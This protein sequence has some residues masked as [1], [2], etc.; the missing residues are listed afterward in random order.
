MRNFFLLSALLFLTKEGEAKLLNPLNLATLEKHSAGNSVHYLPEPGP[1]QLKPHNPDNAKPTDE[2]IADGGYPSET[3]TV[4]TEDGYILRIHRIPYARGQEYNLSRPVVFLQ[5]GLL[6]S[7]ADWVVTGPGHGL[8]F[9][10]ADAGYDVWMGNYRGNTYS[11]NH[12][13]PKLSKK[14]YWTFSWDEMARFDLPA[15]LK[16]MMAVTGS[17]RFF[18]I[19]HSMGTLTYYTA[20]NYHDWIAPATRLMVGYGPH[21]TVQ[22]MQSPVFNLLAEYVDN[23]QWILSE[24]SVYDFLPSNALLDWAASKVCNDD[25]S[26]QAVC[27]NI[28]F[29]VCGYNKHEMNST[30]LPV[31]MGHTPAG[32]S[33]WNMVHYAQSKNHGEWMG[34]DLG[35]DADNLK[36]WNATKPPTYSYKQVTAPTALYWSQNDWLVVPQDAA[37]LN[38]NL[39]NVVKFERVGED[40][41]THLDFLWGVH[42]ME[43]VYG[44]TMDL[45]EQYK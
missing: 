5:H 3:H 43:L 10:L 39:P 31:I 45:M 15:M 38:K 12:K 24:L 23:I 14:Q 35:S 8:A 40:A 20:C 44:P 34:L 7:S 21:T 36:H 16:H 9:H 1:P 13:D 25:M 29:L 2:M 37:I 41:Y 42:N 17:T 33:T 11:R 26:T 28:L 6:S 18:Y 4:T 32:T 19:G 27:R 22:H 30:D